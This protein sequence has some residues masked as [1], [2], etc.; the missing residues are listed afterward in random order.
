MS[1]PNSSGHFRAMVGSVQRWT[2]PAKVRTMSQIQSQGIPMSRLLI[3]EL[4]L[5]QNL[6]GPI[7]RNLPFYFH[8]PY[9]TQGRRC[10][11]NPLKK[12]LKTS[13][14]FSVSSGSQN[15]VKNKSSV[16]LLCFS[17]TSF[18]WAEQFNS[19][20]FTNFKLKI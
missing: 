17:D 10:F 13:H 15:M 6:N 20:S 11:T 1:L 8:N 18:S 19:Q 2:I 7:D 14:I 5:C 9:S 4:S 16:R 3:V 12:V